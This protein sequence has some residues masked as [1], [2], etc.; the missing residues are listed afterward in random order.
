MQTYLAYVLLNND[1]LAKT[2]KTKDEKVPGEYF[3]E[4]NAM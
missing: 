3:Y 4:R 1:Y 2:G